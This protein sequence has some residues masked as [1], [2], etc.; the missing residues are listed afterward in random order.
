[1]NYCGI[2]DGANLENALTDY[3][4][5]YLCQQNV[6]VIGTELSQE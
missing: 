1:M 5:A 3:F 6:C 2:E 4:C